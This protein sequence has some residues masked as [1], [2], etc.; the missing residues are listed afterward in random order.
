MPDTVADRLE[1]IRVCD[2][3]ELPGVC[4]VEA[5]LANGRAVV[6]DRFLDLCGDESPLKLRLRA[7]PVAQVLSQVAEVRLVVQTGKRVV[8]E[9]AA[10]LL[11]GDAV[12]DKVLVRTPDVVDCVLPV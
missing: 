1:D 3:I 10:R 5:R 2:E 8:R 12:G 6:L 4:L 9:Q 11:S 7:E